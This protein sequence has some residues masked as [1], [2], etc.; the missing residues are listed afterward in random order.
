VN[1]ER[2][3]VI[4]S[5]FERHGQTIIGALVLAILLWTGNTVIDIKDKVNR[6]EVFQITAAN[7]D[8]IADRE[9]SDL[10]ERVRTLELDSARGSRK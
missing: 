8:V 4:S 6:I 3:T 7:H 9:V 1:E 5:T 2:S 10:K